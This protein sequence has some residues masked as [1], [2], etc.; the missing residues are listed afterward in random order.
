MPFVFPRN[1]FADGEASQQ[2]R[3]EEA[4]AGGCANEREAGEIE[5]NTAGIG[6]LVDDDV[7][8]EIL[9]VLAVNLVGDRI[10]DYF[11][12]RLRITT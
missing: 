5:A 8:F 10:R 1:R 6:A 12:V 7:Q 9:H 2:G 3:G 4:A 11:D